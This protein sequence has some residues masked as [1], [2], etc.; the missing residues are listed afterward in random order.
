MRK[1]TLEGR[2]VV[3]KTLALSKIVFQS[4]NNIILIHIISELISILKKFIWKNSNPKIKHETLCKE[5]KDVGL[6]NANIPNKILSFQ[7]SW[8][9]RLYKDSFS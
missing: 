4:I 8:V 2:I 3:F 1:L 6:K 5:Y 7:C 9:R